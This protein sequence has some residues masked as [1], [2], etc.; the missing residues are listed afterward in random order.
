MPNNFEEA[1]AATENMF[2]NEQTEPTT[3]ENAGEAN[4]SPD[5]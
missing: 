3:V 1:S 5:R 2:A 4:A